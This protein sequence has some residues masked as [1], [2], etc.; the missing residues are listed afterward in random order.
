[1]KWLVIVGAICIVLIIVIR[2]NQQSDIMTYEEGKEAIRQRDVPIVKKDL[3]ALDLNLDLRVSRAT[4]AG[5]SDYDLTSAVMKNIYPYLS[6]GYELWDLNLTPGQIA[7]YIAEYGEAEVNNGG[8][9]QFFF[10]TSGDYAHELP[11]AFRRIGAP[12]K[13][14]LAERAI[15]VFPQ[16]KCPRDREKRW[17]AMDKIP[18]ADEKLWDKI[19]DEYYDTQEDI[20]DLGVNYV[21]EHPQ[22]FFLD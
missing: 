3:P 12:R 19:D 10:N 14:A 18:E 9:D 21:K 2:S 17:E 8:F 16:G 5:L 6:K 4:V 7:I 11:D 22:E 15:A 20:Y 13:A 1:M